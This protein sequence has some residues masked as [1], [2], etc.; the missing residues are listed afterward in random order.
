MWS[1]RESY[2]LAS[3]ADSDLS[4]CDRCGKPNDRTVDPDFCA[5]CLEIALGNS[6]DACERPN[7]ECRCGH[8]TREQV[9]FDA[10]CDAELARLLTLFGP[11]ILE[12]VP[13][14]AKVPNDLRPTVPVKRSA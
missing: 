12:D 5:P 2:E 14:P 3:R 9:Q 8:L 13:A 1:S 10:D 7:A 6:C 4:P 11:E